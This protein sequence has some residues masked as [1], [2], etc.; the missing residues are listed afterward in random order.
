[1]DD[2]DSETHNIPQYCSTF[3][4]GTWSRLLAVATLRPNNYWAKCL[5]NK[6]LGI[7]AFQAGHNDWVSIIIRNIE[8]KVKLP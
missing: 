7:K 6:S 4:D 1:M 8:H 2:Y 3:S 5:V